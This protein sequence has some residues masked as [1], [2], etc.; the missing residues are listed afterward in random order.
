MGFIKRKPAKSYYLLAI[1]H[2]VALQNQP[3]TT[4]QEARSIYFSVTE[5]MKNYFTHRYRNDYVSLTDHETIQQFA[6]DVES[7][8]LVEQLALILSGA[9]VIKFAGQTALQKQVSK[10]LEACKCI[11][12]ATKPVKKTVDK[13][14]GA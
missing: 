12:K 9:Q 7:E 5:L 3:V 1:E 2:L 10:D 11:I 13:P 4:Y 8:Q 14:G 6:K